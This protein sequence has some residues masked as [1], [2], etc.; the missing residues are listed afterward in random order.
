MTL[1]DVF[2][3]GFTVNFIENSFASEQLSNF[4]NN[5]NRLLQKDARDKSLENEL[6]QLIYGSVDNHEIN[7][8]YAKTINL[9]GNSYVEQILDVIDR[10]D[11]GVLTAGLG[12]KANEAAEDPTSR[13][14]IQKAHALIKTIEQNVQTLLD[15]PSSNAVKTKLEKIKKEMNNMENEIQKMQNQIN[16]DSGKTRVFLSYKDADFW[17]LKFNL[18]LLERYA[19]LINLLPDR[20][21]IGDALENVILNAYNKETEIKLNGLTKR[22]SNVLKTGDKPA[23]RTSFSKNGIALTVA[24]DFSGLD[25]LNKINKNLVEGLKYN[26]ENL[27]IN[28]VPQE[29]KQSKMDIEVS[30]E[31]G[32]SHRFSL[33]NWA[34]LTSTNYLY[35]AGSTDTLSALI[36]SGGI[37]NT[38]NYSL[39]LLSNNENVLTVAHRFAKISIV[40]DILM[41]ISQES[42]WAN[43]LVI[44][45]RSKRQF[46]VFNIP[47]LIQNLGSQ[48]EI[49][50]YR[51]DSLNKI[52]HAILKIVPYIEKGRTNMYIQNMFGVLQSMKVMVRLSNS[53]I[54]SIASKS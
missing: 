18:L 11:I 2:S 23:S 19:N 33:K 31:D 20:K 54:E 41:G 43:E 9:I 26:S 39:A 10:T 4:W 35:G 36:R 8:E 49:I 1:G 3:G 34:N 12:S 15:N 45:D 48:L 5:K 37:D 25:K 24:V 46:Y 22:I 7:T 21:A 40:A 17:H 14:S 42:R 32:S 6:Q 50:G 52:S 28:Y 47:T 51:E 38:N 13:A 44:H 29:E 16:K 53:L 27:K 30:F